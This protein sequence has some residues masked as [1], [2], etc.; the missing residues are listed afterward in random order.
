ML[1]GIIETTDLN[2]KMNAVKIGYFLAEEHGDKG[3][4][5]EAGPYTSE[6]YVSIE[7]K[8]RSSRQTRYLKKSF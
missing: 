8:R 5:T 1:T 4:A 3:I 2:Q 6:I 7:F